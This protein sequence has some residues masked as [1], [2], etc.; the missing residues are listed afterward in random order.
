VYGASIIPGS[1]RSG[2]CVEFL[3]LKPSEYP[4]ISQSL[5]AIHAAIAEVLHMIG[6]GEH[7]DK[8]LEDWQRIHYLD[9]EG[10]DME[11]L[12]ARLRLVMAS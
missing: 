1:V 2:E 11:L 9:E 12:S 5:I 8:I 7:I 4:S 10:A 3:N 6:A